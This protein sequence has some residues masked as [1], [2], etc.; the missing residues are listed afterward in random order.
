MSSDKYRQAI[1]SRVCKIL[2]DERVKRGISMTSLGVST[3]LSQQAISYVEREMRIPNLDTLLRITGAL[4]ISLGDV[5]SQAMR[6][7][8]T[9]SANK[10]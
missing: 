9:T 8:S 2:Q 7:V 10:N 1:C 5:I 6:E 3:G 4:K